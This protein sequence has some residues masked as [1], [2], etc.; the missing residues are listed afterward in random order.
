MFRHFRFR[1]LFR[2]LL[3]TSFTLHTAPLFAQQSLFNVPSVDT[4][5]KDKI[6]FQE[7]INFSPTGVANTTLDYGL[8][9]GWEIGLSFFNLDFYSLKHTWN[10]ASL[11]LNVQQGFH[12]TEQWK[13]GIGT[14]SGSTLPMYND[15]AHFSSFNYWNNALDLSE[16]GKYYLGVYYANTTFVANGNNVNLMAGME[17]PVTKDVHMMADFINGNN[18]ISG[19]VIGFVWYATPQWQVSLGC[20]FS[21][22]TKATSRIKGEAAVFELTY[23]Q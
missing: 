22:P 23:V 16:W 10:N 19:A 3:F 1:Y 4:T 9:N 6:F 21:T 12:I 15:S 13:V 11:L 7:Q 14:Q 17:L 5:E 18:D 2:Y 8:G 20:Q